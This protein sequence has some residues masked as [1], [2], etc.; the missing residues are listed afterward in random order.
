MVIDAPRDLA[1]AP[2]DDVPVPVAVVRLAAGRPM[3]PVWQNMLGGLTYEIPGH[4]FIKW[5]PLGV[6][7]HPEAERLAWA[8]PFTP[9]PRLLDHG[10][11]DDGSWLITEPLAG[12]N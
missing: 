8:A 7:L 3:R 12:T 5:A 11:D 6:D 2:G 4:C 10:A 1:G 9:V